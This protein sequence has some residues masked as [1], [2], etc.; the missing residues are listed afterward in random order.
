M[1]AGAHLSTLF[2]GVGAF[3]VSFRFVFFLYYY[4]PFQAPGSSNWYSFISWYT[5]K[6]VIHFFFVF[7]FL[8]SIRF[9]FLCF[10][11]V[12][13]LA[14][15]LT[16]RRYLVLRIYMVRSN[17]ALSLFFFILDPCFFRF[18]FLVFSV[19]CLYVLPCPPLPC[20][21]LPCFGLVLP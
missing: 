17:F 21:A 8:F 18:N 9:R 10:F 3:L 19:S 2:I 1:C 5:Y 11:G 15:A 12:S 13:C 6:F 14:F 4:V 7:V 20:L 16:R